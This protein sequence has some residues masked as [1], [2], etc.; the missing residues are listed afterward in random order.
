MVF[1]NRF[2]E[3]VAFV[4]VRRTVGGRVGVVLVCEF[5]NELAGMRWFRALLTGHGDRSQLQV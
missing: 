4:D 3:F 5:E 1:E 2:A